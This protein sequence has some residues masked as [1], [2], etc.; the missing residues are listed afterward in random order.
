MGGNRWSA[1]ELGRP[2]LREDSPICGSVCLCGGCCNPSKC[3]T[4]HPPPLSGQGRAAQPER[5]ELPRRSWADVANP[6]TPRLSS[7]IVA[8][9]PVE[10]LLTPSAAA[11]QAHGGS[12]ALGHETR[13]AQVSSDP[14]PDGRKW[15]RVLTQREKSLARRQDDRPRHKF[16]E[17]RDPQ[18]C[19]TPSEL[20]TSSDFILTLS[21]RWQRDMVFKGRY[22]EVASVK[23]QLQSWFPPS[24][25]S[26][27]WWF[28]CRV[29]IERLPLGKDFCCRSKLQS[30]TKSDCC[31]LFAWPWTWDA[32][33]IPCTSEFN[34]LNRDEQVR[35]K[36]LLS[37]GRPTEQGKERPHFPVLIHLDVVKDFTPL[38]P[39]VSPMCDED[40]EWSRV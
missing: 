39:A 20:A 13:G 35:S 3:S 27:V 4:L 17:C 29:A 40:I 30:L 31:A 5:L 9:A 26:R 18:I 22:V 34:V 2:D 37:E 11:S 33:L 28:Y 38:S 8:P 16:F 7:N 23:F 14:A 15:T 25:D 21:E 24:S 10:A 36:E 1:Q 6:D 19:Y 12:L 32:D